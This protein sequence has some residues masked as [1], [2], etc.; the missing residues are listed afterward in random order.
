MRIQASV[1]QPC[2]FVVSIA[3]LVLLLASLCALPAHSFAVDNGIPE[4]YKPPMYNSIP[5]VQFRDVFETETIEVSGIRVDMEG[6]RTW[7]ETVHFRIFNSTTQETEYEVDTINPEGYCSYLPPLQ[8]KKKHDY[9][10]FVEDPWY[11]LGTKKYVQI[12]DGSEHAATD[13]PGAYDY[14]RDASGGINMGL[15]YVKL[16]SFKVYRRDTESS[17]PF[18]DNRFDTDLSNTLFPLNVYYKGRLLTENVK[19]NLVS[20]IETIPVVK[21]ADGKIK[22]HLIEDVTYMVYVESDKYIIDPFP[23]VAKDKSEYG[24]G[25]YCYDHSTCNRVDPQTRPIVLYDPGEKVFDGFARITTLKSLKGRTTVSGMNFRHLVLLDRKLDTVVPQLAGK[26][27]EVVDVTA[28]NPHRWEIS[29]LKGT[30]FTIQQT[31]PNGKSVV[32]VSALENGKLAPLQFTQKK[33]GEVEF[34]SDSLSLHPYVIEYKSQATLDLSKATV[35]KVADTVYTG[36]AI[37]PDLS[38]SYSGAKLKAGTDYTIAWSNNVNVGTATAKLT[39]KGVF[40]NTKNVTFKIVPASISKATVNGVV[41]KTYN[42]KAQTQSPSVIVKVG[43]VNRVLKQGT[44][45]T[46]TY[47]NNTNAGT[48]TMT[49]TGKGNFA[50]SISKTFKITKPANT[51]V[52][53]IPVYWIVHKKTGENLYTTAWKEVDTLC[54]KKK[55]WTNKGIM[56]HAPEKGEPVYRLYN[57]KTGDHHFTKSANEVRVLTKVKK[58]WSADFNGK[59]IFYSGGTKGIWRLY[60]DARWKAGKAGTHQ[61]AISAASANKLAK[62]GWSN[63]GVLLY[64]V[65]YK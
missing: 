23:I 34:I 4:G 32:S 50:G 18:A 26:D 29:K 54:N 49:I 24:E 48:A 22:A 43:G 15:T 57:P 3:G 37:Q 27:Y 61:F 20:D 25:R 56:W 28:V 62:S 7:D 46:I 14:K 11:Q 60:S 45:Y 51:I 19:F 59:P 2:S 47:K 8:L 58:T 65:K 42:G 12:L 44:D 33:N 39:G 13:G 5:H 53:T 10:F 38:V 35:G 17:D 31:I 1:N 64:A 21:G 40:K 55:T 9:I 16:N 41:N 30:P 6:W 36:K 52:K 63:E